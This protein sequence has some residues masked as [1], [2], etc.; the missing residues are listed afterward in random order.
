[1]NGNG[2]KKP[3]DRYSRFGVFVTD[4]NGLIVKCLNRKDAARNW[5]DKHEPG[6]TPDEKRRRIRTFGSYRRVREAW[7]EQI[8]LGNTDAEVL[9]I[10]TYYC[11]VSTAKGFDLR[12]GKSM[13]RRNRA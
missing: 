2:K 7:D 12:R 10:M 8:R 3:F 11:G 13:P 6:L 4:G 9:A 5:L 1:M